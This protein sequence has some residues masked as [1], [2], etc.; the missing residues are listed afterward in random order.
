M[1]SRSTVLITTCFIVSLLAGCSRPSLAVINERDIPTYCASGAMQA[2]A[3]D[4]A[5]SPHSPSPPQRSR[6][7]GSSEG[8]T[9]R[10]TLFQKTICY[11]QY[12]YVCDEC[13]SKAAHK[14]SIDCA[15]VGGL[16]SAYLPAFCY[17]E[18]Y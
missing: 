16:G 8:T 12:A 9:P 6:K 11:T 7:L 17:V 5:A 14:L 15:Q 4:A 3:A 2:A 10:R 1:A 13:L 18:N